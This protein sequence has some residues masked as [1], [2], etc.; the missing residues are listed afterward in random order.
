MASA[1]EGAPVTVALPSPRPS[2]GRKAGALAPV[3]GRW[4]PGV[5]SGSPRVA[6]GSSGLLWPSRASLPS[7][8][9]PARPHSALGRNS[10]YGGTV[11]GPVAARSVASG[12]GSGWW[13]LLG[14]FAYRCGGTSR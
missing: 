4:R 13:R 10:R 5:G 8:K 2:L 9:R 11:M 12:N 3:P 1:S 7:I 6:L 14:K